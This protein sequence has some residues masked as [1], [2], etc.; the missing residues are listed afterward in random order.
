[1]YW[2]GKNHGTQSLNGFI[3]RFSLKPHTEYTDLLAGPSMCTNWTV[4]L[5]FLSGGECGLR[6]H[7][8][9]SYHGVILYNISFLMQGGPA[10]WQFSTDNLATLICQLPYNPLG[11]YNSWPWPINASLSPSCSFYHSPSHSILAGYKLSEEGPGENLNLYE[12]Y[13]YMCTLHYLQ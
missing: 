2:G 9:I 7:I 5:D 10:W 6:Y 4:L 1:M 11:E 8:Y 12:G 13:I 3:Q